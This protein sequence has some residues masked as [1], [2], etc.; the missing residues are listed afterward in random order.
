MH[1]VTAGITGHTVVFNI[2]LIYKKTNKCNFVIKFLLLIPQYE[3]FSDLDLLDD[4]VNFSSV[5]LNFLHFFLSRI[6]FL[7]YFIKSLGLISSF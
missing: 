5:F 3:W 1:A 7:R 4:I 6:N 2:L